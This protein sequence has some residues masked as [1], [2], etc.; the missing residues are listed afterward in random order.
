MEQ[1]RCEGEQE[2]EGGRAEW[3]GGA[4][5]A[6]EDG[7]GESVEE[8]LVV[9]SDGG[10]VA[11]AADAGAQLRPVLPGRLTRVA[12]PHLGHRALVKQEYFEFYL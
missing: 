5:D 6:K 10:E 2:E 1:G 4:A 11:D 3:R 12:L 9:A 7:V 8:H